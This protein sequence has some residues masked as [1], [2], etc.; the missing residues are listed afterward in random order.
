MACDICWAIPQLQEKQSYLVHLVDKI[1]NRAGLFIMQSECTH[2]T[3][4]WVQGL[5]DNGSLVVTNPDDHSD[6]FSMANPVVV[7]VDD[8]AARHIPLVDPVN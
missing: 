3:Q 6:Q 4:E 2:D 1:T 8:K 5:A 7:H